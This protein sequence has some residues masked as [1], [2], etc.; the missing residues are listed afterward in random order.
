MNDAQTADYIRRANTEHE[1][2]AHYEHAKEKHPYFCDTLLPP[3]MKR[4]PDFWDDLLR[5]S[6]GE[7]YEYR[8]GGCVPAKSVFKCELSEME[9]AIAHDDKSAAV[10]EAYD[11]IAVL[12]RII[13]VLEGRQ[14]LGKPE[15]EP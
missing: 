1:I 3:V 4:F 10:E 7:L 11:C 13:D 9:A 8:R 12:L 5:G 6:R 15:E 2:W 14:K